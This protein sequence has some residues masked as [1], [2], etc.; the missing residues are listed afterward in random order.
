MDAAEG[1]PLAENPCAGR[2][3]PGNRVGTVPV[4]RMYGVTAAGNSVLVHIH[5]FTPYFFVMPAP[6]MREADLPAWE[7]ALEAQLAGAGTPPPPPHS[8]TH[9]HT[10][11]RTYTHAHTQSHTRTC[12]AA[13]L[14]V[15][16]YSL[17]LYFSLYPDQAPRAG[18]QRRC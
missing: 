18:T 4:I 17:V 13:P 1:P 12:A 2:N 7:A 5:G 15:P 6:G 8:H 3:M 9:K 16:T 14:A 11:S 10:H